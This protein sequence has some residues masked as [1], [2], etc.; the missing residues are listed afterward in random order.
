MENTLKLIHK[1]CPLINLIIKP[2]RSIHSMFCSMT[3]FLCFKRSHDDLENI[4][5]K[6]KCSEDELKVM[7]KRKKLSYSDLNSTF[8]EY[9]EESETKVNEGKNIIKNNKPRFNSKIM[10]NIDDRSLFIKNSKSKDELNEKMQL[11]EESL[12]IKCKYCGKE[13]NKAEIYCIY[14]NYYC[15]ERCRHLMYKK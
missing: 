3:T 8:K 14:D 2:V 11:F 1:C 7:I 4:K 12:Y 5:V 10:F 9:I 6:E 13:V 15:S